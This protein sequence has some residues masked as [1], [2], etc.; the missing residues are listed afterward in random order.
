VAFFG[1]G[2]IL[3]RLCCCRQFRKIETSRKPGSFVIKRARKSHATEHGCKIFSHWLKDLGGLKEY[4]AVRMERRRS[5][6]R[7]RRNKHKNL[8]IIVGLMSIE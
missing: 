2:P 5:Q 8:Y 6:H 7:R 1:S 4:S 3:N